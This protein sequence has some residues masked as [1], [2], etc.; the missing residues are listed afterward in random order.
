M[1]KS[2]A[3]LL[4]FAV[5][6]LA[7]MVED[8]LADQG[9]PILQRYALSDDSL[10]ALS[11]RAAAKKN[12]IYVQP[13]P[14]NPGKV[15]G[16]FLAGAIGGAVFGYVGARVGWDMTYVE[17]KSD[18]FMDFNFSGLPGLIV[19]YFV[20]SNV[21]SAAGVSLVGNTGGESGSYWA[22]VGGSVAGTVVGGLLAAGIISA[23][24]DDDSGGAALLVL[25][26]AQAGGAAM[27]FNATR[28]KKVEVS[29]GALLNLQE[30]G[31]SLAFPQVSVSPD[32]FGSSN[33]KV[34]LI[35][36]RF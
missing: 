24:D 7:G 23:S 11:S 25:P 21:G 20:F 36:A 33:Y 31:M 30:G 14:A 3:F 17:R 16:E 2:I 6:L 19:G 9:Q 5:I 22:S 29:G 34:S 18:G 28:K 1:K 8:A 32:P 27:G 26:L 10:R 4:G 15:A 13:G 35:G 12:F